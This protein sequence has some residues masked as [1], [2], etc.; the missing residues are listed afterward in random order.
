MAAQRHHSN[1]I[2]EN[3]IREADG[4][5]GEIRVGAR[6]VVVVVVLVDGEA[7]DAVAGDEADEEAE[8]DEESDEEDEFGVEIERV[9]V[10]RCRIISTTTHLIH[11]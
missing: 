7:T 10:R 2:S 6:E 5:I 4:A 9:V 11:G 3:K 1:L 8:D